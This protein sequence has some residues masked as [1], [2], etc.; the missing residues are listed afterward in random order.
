MEDSKVSL[1][2]RSVPDDVK[3]VM[4]RLF[5]RGFD[6]WVVGGALRD[7]MLG[8]VP[9]DW[10]LATDAQAQSVLK[11]FPRV[12]PIGIRHGTVQ[13]LT[14]QMGIEIT[15]TPGAGLE[16]ILADLGRRDFT[17]NALALAYP[18]WELLD[19]Y[20]GE[21][22]LEALSLKAVGDAQSRF[23]EDPLRTLRAGRLMSTH[24]FTI[25]RST[26]EA[27]QQEAGGL[28][29]AAKER[30]RDEMLKMLLGKQ[31]MEA[32]DWMRRG[33]VILRALPEL[34]DGY[35]KG[36][37]VGPPFDVYRHLLHT[38]HCSPMRLRVRLAALFH[39]IARPRVCGRGS[40]R[41]RCSGCSEASA[42][43][44]AEVMTRWCMSNR[45]IRE[46]RTLVANHLPRDAE[47]WDDAA[48]RRLIS[49]VGPELLEDLLDL[50]MADR[51]SMS[52]HE[53]SSEGMSLLRLRIY[54]Q[55]GRGLP[56]RVQ[57]LA[58]DGKDVMRALAL[59]PG[60]MIGKILSFLHRKVLEAPDLNER[61]IL[62]DFL[63]KEFH[64][65][66]LASN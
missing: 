10:D 44:A 31:V 26:F 59:K 8:R 49:S 27:L 60:P 32:F 28:E 5:E 51:F 16:G 20:G 56:F 24:G 25:Q 22:D 29:R 47:Q 63:E 36:L 33:G 13:V 50:A 35:E 65:E 14:E 9:K 11:L 19:P 41:L 1:I 62:M 53:S 17:I 40:D 6:V 58:I 64:E 42:G 37:D 12:V 66:E 30:I 45:E 7:C 46:I 57:D 43:V 39:D 34:L 48:L 15:T 18:G 3:K 2:V 54:E 4:S 55:L 21:K 52:D 38:V 61:K 23:R